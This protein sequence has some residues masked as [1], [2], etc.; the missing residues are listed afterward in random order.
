MLAT[1]VKVG[2]PLVLGP[3]VT[4][5]AM[6]ILHGLTGIAVVGIGLVATGSLVSQAFGAL[7]G[8]LNPNKMR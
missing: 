5:V 7:F 8:G 2:A 3:I 1:T 6:P 4:P